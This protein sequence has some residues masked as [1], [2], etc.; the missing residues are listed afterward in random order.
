MHPYTERFDVFARNVTHKIS[1]G[2]HRPLFAI[3]LRPNYSS[4]IA[5]RHDVDACIWQPQL[6]ASD[7]LI[8]HEG[9]LNAFGYVQASKQQKKF[10]QCS[11]DFNYAIICETNRNIFI[12][13]SRFN[14]DG[15]LKNRKGGKSAIGEQKL[16]TL[17]GG[18]EILGINCMDD[19]TI[20]LTE[21][22]VICLQVNVRS[23]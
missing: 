8:N 23:E 3:Q 18:D 6:T 5:L 10:Q 12:Y 7:W 4:A 1:L 16:V 13:Y 17:D 22:S 14:T 9:T 20:L 11:P 19:V 21:N 15:E 2:M